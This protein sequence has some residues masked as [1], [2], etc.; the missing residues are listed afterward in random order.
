MP[1]NR[2]EISGAGQPYP[3]RSSS[4]PASAPYEAFHTGG[5]P[6]CRSPKL[7]ISATR[8]TFPSEPLG[9]RPSQAAIPE[10]WVS[11]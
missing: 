10:G 3:Y 8:R 9:L 1:F 4:T 6:A 7:T 2:A 5:R 11:G